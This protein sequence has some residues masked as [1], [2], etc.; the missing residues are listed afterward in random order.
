MQWAA[1]LGLLGVLG[2]SADEGPP[3]P[4]AD[5]DPI[6][7][8]GCAVSE[9]C[10]ILVESE[11]PYRATV[12]CVPEG[13]QVVGGLCG[14][15]EPGPD[16]FDNCQAG[17]VCLDGLCT[18]VCALAGDDC[19]GEQACIA[20][21]GVFDG[22]DVGLCTALCA[23]TAAD[24]CAPGQGCYLALGTGQS[25]CHAAGSLGQGEVCTYIDDCGEGLGCV[26]LGA[27]GASTLCTAFC[28]PATGVTASGQTCVQ[29][30][31]GQAGAPACIAINRFYSDTPAVSNQVGMCLDCADPG[32]ADLAV[33]SS[34][35]RLAR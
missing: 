16:G 28:D 31:G 17:S 20:H 6:S 34:A 2:C 5:C 18:P 12:R 22:R 26:L 27:D 15:N 13:N 25:T 8:E 32:Y 30:L 4:P 33:C 24:S 21:G 11:S 23:P 14:F 3:P 1:S 7:H 29:A 19:T 35:A 9:K 10:S